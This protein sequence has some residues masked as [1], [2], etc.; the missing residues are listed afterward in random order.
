MG[1]L[2]ELLVGPPLLT[3]AA[4]ESLTAGR[5]QSF[6]A[7]DSGSSAYFLGGVTAYSLEQKVALLKV[8]PVHARSV[9]C[10]SA[11]VAEE[12]ALGV[13]GLFGS[14]VGVATTGYAEPWPAEGISEPF[15]FWAVAYRDLNHAWTIRTGRVELSGLDRI[16]AQQSAANAATSALITLL[17]AVRAGTA[18]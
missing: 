8:E 3:V 12:M 6:I 11:R 14:R 17:Q 15:A 16:G 4:A 13:C 18:L 7:A 10:V 2:K 5:V 1:V 9:N